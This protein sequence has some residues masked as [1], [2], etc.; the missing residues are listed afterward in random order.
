MILKA[1]TIFLSVL[2]IIISF[3]T[4]QGQEARTYDGIANNIDNPSW[5]SAGSTLQLK[6]ATAFSD[7]YKSPAGVNRPNARYISNNLFE[8]T[9]SIPNELNISDFGW[10]FGQFIDHDV[11]FVDEMQNE[12]ISIEID[13][14]DE[15]F[16]PFC[17]GSSIM[18]IRRSKYSPNSGDEIG[19]PRIF[20]NEITA[21]ID[22][23]TVYGSDEERANW[24]RTF[25]NGKLKT[26][27]GNFL[28][29]NTIS[30][31]KE[32]TVD[33]FAPFMLLEG[34]IPVRHFIAG[35]LRANEQPGLTCLHTLFVREHNRICE[36]L[37]LQHP[38]WTD[39]QIYQMARK[40]VGGIIQNIVYQEFLPA[41]GIEI[42]EY[43]S[44]SP[45]TNP[46]IFNIF[47]AGA[48]RLGHSLV[49]EQII[50]L[51]DSGDS[52]IFGSVHIKDAF[53][54]PLV[55]TEEGGI[56]PFFKGMATQ[57]QQAFDTK[58]VGTLRNFLFGA[59]GAGG[60]DLVSLNIERGRERGLADYNTIRQNFNLP[61]IQ[62]FAH[63][64]QNPQTENALR[65]IYQ[66]VFD[67][68]PWV[69]MLAETP[70][71][72][73]TVGELIHIIL[74]EQFEA[75]RDGDRFYFENDSA[76][77]SS[78][79]QQI[80]STTLADIILR[81]TSLTQIQENV[82]FA[83]PSNQLTTVA[84]EP[85]E[86][87]QSIELLA[88]PNPVAKY[89]QVH[90]QSLEPTEMTLTITDVS[91]K[92]YMQQIFKIEKGNNNIQLDLNKQFLTGVYFIEITGKNANGKL[93]IVKQ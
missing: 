4:I 53:F 55:I 50:R 20:V 87:I 56:A 79:K 80:K 33:P 70:M 91:G 88:Y 15:Y 76:F 46:S 25:E 65:E 63:I 12:F 39:E 7:G 40:W 38:N 51:E 90:L 78:E 37:I 26:S 85:F 5:G 29:F 48:Y 3:P 86:N 19:N 10:N 59:P 34:T 73:K 23:S 41:L 69:G 66:N 72:G 18:P 74:K 67:I 47:S 89:L 83:E 24:L 77:T 81:N 75:L 22:A 31:E 92:R 16:D 61:Q 60:L 1:N 17:N 30:G 58:V 21:F 14:C 13:D 35:D 82:F 11:T 8:Q 42:S 71:E 36:D 68:D 54:N 32:D 27:E 45:T 44:Y 9:N 84:I 52:L 62:N 49:N 64:T 57:R 43:Q 28:P 2:I 93:K 6:T